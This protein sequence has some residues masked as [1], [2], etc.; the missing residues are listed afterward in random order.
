MQ[1]SLGLIKKYRLE[2]CMARRTYYSLRVFK[3]LCII[4]HTSSSIRT[5]CLETIRVLY[6]R[7]QAA[8][9]FTLLKKRRYTKEIKFPTRWSALPYW[10][11][12]PSC[13]L[14]HSN[15]VFPWQSLSRVWTWIHGS[16]PKRQLC[17]KPRGWTFF[18]LHSPPALFNV[19]LHI[20][21]LHL[22]IPVQCNH[23]SHSPAEQPYPYFRQL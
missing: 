2:V 18:T 7:T 16:L 20:E 12:H 19:I 6:C 17:T 4:H 11:A 10:S 23:Y 1:I 8:N 21:T 14:H 3:S 15:Q 5:I 22:H 9:I 13:V